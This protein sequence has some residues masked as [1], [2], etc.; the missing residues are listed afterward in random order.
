MKSFMMIIL[1]SSLISCKINKQPQSDVLNKKTV[2]Y[3]QSYE[4][5]DRTISFRN[6][7]E[8]LKSKTIYFVDNKLVDYKYFRNLLDENK[9]KNFKI[10]DDSIEILKMDFSYKKVKKIIVVSKK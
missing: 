1:A 10:I 3:N 5:H 2:D 8:D 4:Y 6:F 9:I 7:E